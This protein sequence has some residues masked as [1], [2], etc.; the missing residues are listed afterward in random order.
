MKERMAALVRTRTRDEWCE[1]LEGTDV[2]FA[3][4]LGMGEAPDHP[5]NR[6]RG[7]F[8]ELGGVRQPGPAPRFSRTQPE[9]RRPAPHPGQ[10][11]EEALRS[12]GF[13][14]EEIA[15]LREARAIA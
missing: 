11:T 15:K 13:S 8:V 6:A 10:D 9:L 4:V 2:C 12:W 14:P 5:H 7:T 1:I 3:L